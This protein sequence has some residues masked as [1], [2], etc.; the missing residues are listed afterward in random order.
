M[1]HGV[2]VKIV[3]RL[4]CRDLVM[5]DIP[6]WWAKGDW[7]DV[8]SCNIACPCEFAQ[9]PTNN[10]C[11]ALLAWHIDD[12][13]YGG[14]SLKGFNAVAVAS[15]DDN[16]WEG[17]KTIAMGVFVDER[18][19]EAERE[20]LGQIFSGHAGGFMANIGALVCDDLGVQYAPISFEL[21]DDLAYWRANIPGMVE[22]EGQA[23]GGPTTPPGKRVQLVNPP[24][25]EVG[26]GGVATWA[27]A[28][29]NK[30][31]AFGHNWDWSG[32]SSKHIPFDWVGP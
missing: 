9:A 4:K 1:P 21:A 13:E 7:F 3:H 20:A 18:A 5:S 27:T 16:I 32:Q 24:G 26:P 29:R 22:A 19:N 23:L 10:H 6:S 2:A 11:E 15:F 14:V 12:G 8:C 25:S 17:A 30:V 28:T 31:E